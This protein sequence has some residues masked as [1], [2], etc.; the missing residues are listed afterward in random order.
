MSTRKKKLETALDNLFSSPMLPAGPEAN[1]EVLREKH[2]PAVKFPEPQPA[3]PAEPIPDEP[4]PASQEGCDPV[5]VSPVAARQEAAVVEGKPE[6]A[7]AQP[8]PGSNL[9]KKNSSSR[10][11]QAVVFTLAGEDY[12]VNI[13]AVESIIKIQAITQVPNTR[14]Y[15]AGVTNLR[16]TVLPV[17]D[18]RDRFGLTA[19]DLGKDAR[20]VVVSARDEKIGMIVDTVQ[21]VLN[22]QPE[23]V[24]ALPAAAG[25][26]DAPYIE[27]IA[28]VDG[29]LII[30]LNLES[31]LWVKN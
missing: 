30:L 25:G 6:T 31:V 4:A 8:T 11:S 22:I 17:I 12:G 19:G 26:L 2:Q 5:T 16:G 1:P 27:G 7:P 13:A 10:P 21:E 24:E 20:I 28:K 3:Q 29:R 23:A 15:I 14:K 9:T 18:L